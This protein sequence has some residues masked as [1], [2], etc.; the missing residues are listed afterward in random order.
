MNIENQYHK[1]KVKNFK[2]WA[3]SPDGLKGESPS[4]TMQAS[5]RG[6]AKLA[7]FMANK[8]KLGN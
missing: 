3:Q 1:N 7:G 6:L 8:G 2:I 5:A 4:F